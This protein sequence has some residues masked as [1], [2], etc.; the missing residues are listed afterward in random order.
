MENI[1]SMT[2]KEVLKGL[3]NIAEE[4][5]LPLQDYKVFTEWSIQNPSPCGLTKQ[6]YDELI[7][8]MYFRETVF[9]AKYDKET[10]TTYIKKTKDSEWEKVE[11]I[12]T[13]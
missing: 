7:Y 6:T 4:H 2:T 12:R 11:L 13:I 5:T 9:A 10:K 3:L 1:K 8:P